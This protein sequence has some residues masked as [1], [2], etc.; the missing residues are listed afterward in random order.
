[1]M[2]PSSRISGRTLPFPTVVVVVSSRLLSP[3]LERLF[4]AADENPPRWAKHPPVLSLDKG[5]PHF[6][7]P[8]LTLFLEEKIMFHSN[9]GPLV[10]RWELRLSKP[11]SPPP[12]SLPLS[13]RRREG[14]SVRFP[15]SIERIIAAL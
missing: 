8:H 11:S 6:P 3:L 5:T 4:D 10:A 14:L 15:F 12:T 1:M 9:N 2:V 13:C 7:P